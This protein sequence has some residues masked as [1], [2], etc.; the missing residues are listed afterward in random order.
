[1]N[2]TGK[3]K[4]YIYYSAISDSKLV[5]WTYF[6]FSG[7]PFNEGVHYIFNAP[8]INFHFLNDLPAKNISN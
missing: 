4:V 7:L 8:S 2:S 1:M 3:I 5:N 6:E